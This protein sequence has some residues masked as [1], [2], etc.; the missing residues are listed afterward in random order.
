MKNRSKSFSEK[1]KDASTQTDLAYSS[2][3]SKESMKKFMENKHKHHANTT[4][5]EELVKSSVNKELEEK[6]LEFKHAIHM[7][8]RELFNSIMYSNTEV[9]V[10]DTVEIAGN[11]T[12]ININQ[13]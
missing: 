13:E 3:S 10:E 6:F 5:L 9:K 11:I 2:D 8:I 1:A 4:K 12:D 7:D